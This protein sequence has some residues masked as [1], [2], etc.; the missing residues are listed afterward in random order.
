MNAAMAA[1]PPV[2]IDIDNDL[3][4]LK[5][6][7]F[8]YLI[9]F[10][11]I[12]ISRILDIHLSFLHLPLILS[13]L[14]AITAIVSGTILRGTESKVGI[15]YLVLTALF[16]IGIPFAYW[17]GGV[18]DVLREH[19]FDT[20]MAWFLITGLTLSYSQAK[21]LLNTIAYAVI[22]AGA[23]GLVYGRL[24]AEGRLTL[25][26]GRLANPNDY[27]ATL[28][29]GLPFIWRLF[30]S[31]SA[32]MRIG[33]L[34]ATA[35]VF[36]CFA[37]TGSRSAVLGLIV[38]IILGIAQ[39]PVITKI[40]SC[41]VVIVLAFGAVMFMPDHLRARYLTF[42]NANAADSFQDSTSQ[43]A[44]GYAAS[45]TESRMFVLKESLD[46]TL[47]HPIFG[48]G[49]GNFAAYENAAALQKAGH[50]GLWV[51]THNTYTQLS[52]EAGIPGA[53]VFISILV[54][55]WRSMSKLYRK[56]RRDPRPAARDVYLTAV[57]MRLSLASFCTFIFFEHAAYDVWCHVVTA[58]A[59]VVAREANAHLARLNA[60]TQPAVVDLPFAAGGYAPSLIR[61]S[62]Q[63]S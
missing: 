3:A 49:L 43:L 28:L 19:W 13:T 17:R 27:A 9:I 63:H 39:A 55:C 6:L 15:L 51:G 36:Y 50:K 34:V 14:A 21:R 5:K 22:T 56:T 33:I 53:L 62:P 29:F 46:I 26:Q 48:I 1:A 4:P 10:V 59:V 24:T 47:H 45:S 37:K 30:R 23:L 52:S 57:A 25:V 31:K 7:G 11:Y 35:P 58:C 8:L 32:F 40:V 60:A 2:K 44:A 12:L 18:V 38:M 61:R 16:I 54:L 42:N 41:V 20:I